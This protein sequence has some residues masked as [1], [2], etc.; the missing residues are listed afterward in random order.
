MEEEISTKLTFASAKTLEAEIKKRMSFSSTKDLIIGEIKIVM[1]VR[2]D[3]YILKTFHYVGARLEDR[4][5]ARVELNNTEA[6][7]LIAYRLHSDILWFSRKGDPFTEYRLDESS[8]R[9]LAETGKY[10]YIDEEHSK[11]LKRI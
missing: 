4:F 3:W 2:N 1:F 7:N 5:I 8:L 10:Y 9:G 11:I 6:E